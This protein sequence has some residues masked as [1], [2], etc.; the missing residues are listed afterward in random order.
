MS[1]EN[2]KNQNS[3]IK[4]ALQILPGFLVCVVIAIVSKIIAKLFLPTLG[5][6]TIAIIIGIIV[7][8]TFG[9]KEYLNKGTK[10]SEGTLL[11][12]SVV[13][14]GGTL[15]ISQLLDLGIRGI[16]FI[17]LL[18]LMTLFGTIWVGRY[19]KFGEDFVLLMASGNAVCGSSAIASTAPVI[20]A[21]SRD[22]GIAITMV[23]VT[24]TV[25]MILLPLLTSFLYNNET[26]RTSAFLGGILQSVGQVVAAGSMVSEQV[27]EQA[28]IF[29]I[30]RIV[31]LVV[32]VFLL[33]ALKKKSTVKGVEAVEE[34]IHSHNH[35]SRIK[36]PWYI[37][38]FFITCAL[39]SLNI[40]PHSLTH[41]LKELDNFIEVIALAGIGMRVYFK[42]LI[43]QGPKASMYCVFIAL[44]QIISAIVLIGVLL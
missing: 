18:M 35:Q 11:S 2:N 5:A 33:A 1:N 27:K 20:N 32:V 37:I 15:N 30:V 34:E 38:G 25:L 9:R 31:F 16:L 4:H 22:K 39:Y 41:T 26:F 21:H 29:K 3:F 23:N 36:I 14:L 8:N 42:D 44:I 13:L 40:I 28:T 17:I 6:A 10:F 7:G 43:Q 12:I 24:G 19:L